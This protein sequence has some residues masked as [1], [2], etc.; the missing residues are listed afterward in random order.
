[1]KAPHFDVMRTGLAVTLGT[2][3]FGLSVWTLSTLARPNGVKA[4]VDAVVRQVDRIEQ[5]SRTPGAA[6]RYP[7]GAVCENVTTGL[8]N[9]QGRLAAAAS[10]TSV[11]LVDVA[12]TPRSEPTEGAGPTS[13]VTFKLQADGNYEAVLLMLDVLDK[14]QPTILVDSVD[15]APKASGVR[16]KMSG[17]VLCW[18]YAHR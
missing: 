16:L 1:M 6:D 18:T 2:C 10:A 5:L 15:L 4:R 17:E 9:L 7:A 3:A 12:V 14:A 13:P 8:Q 11:K